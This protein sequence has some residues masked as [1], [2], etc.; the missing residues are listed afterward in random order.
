MSDCSVLD[1]SNYL[2]LLNGVLIFFLFCFETGSCW[3]ELEILLIQPP[4][5]WDP[6]WL[7][8]PWLAKGLS[9]GWVVL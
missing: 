2:A 3:L 7:G 4:E 1:L 8:L 5:H 6:S 9:F